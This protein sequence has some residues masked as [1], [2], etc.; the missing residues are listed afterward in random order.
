M[1]LECLKEKLETVKGGIMEDMLVAD[2]VDICCI[3]DETAEYGTM[4]SVNEVDF[5]LLC[6]KCKTK[7]CRNCGNAKDGMCLVHEVII[8]DFDN[9]VCDTWER[10]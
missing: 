4:T 7:R 5:E 6:D 8:E 2:G 9:K 1:L 3:C 10:D